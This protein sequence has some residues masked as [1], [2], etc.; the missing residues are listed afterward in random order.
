MV[1]FSS[2]YNM[3]SDFN[4]NHLLLCFYLSFVMRV[5]SVDYQKRVGKTSLPSIV[6]QEMQMIIKYDNEF[7]RAIFDIDIVSRIIF[8]IEFII[9]HIVLL[10][11]WSV[12]RNSW[13]IYPQFYIMFVM[14]ELLYPHCYVMLTSYLLHQRTK[15]KSIYICLSF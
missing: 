6:T 7:F 3:E 4:V 15:S 8:D 11:W 14:F 2:S 10:Q 9:K 5:M 13:F 12:F 1:T